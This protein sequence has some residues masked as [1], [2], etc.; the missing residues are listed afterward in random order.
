MRSLHPAPAALLSA[1]TEPPVKLDDLREAPMFDGFA[2]FVILVVGLLVA[3]ALS[4]AVGRTIA[5]VRSQ[6]AALIVER[7]LVTLLG[8]AAIMAALHQLGVGLSVLLGTAGIA[9]I[10]LGFAAQTSASNMISGMFLLAEQPFRVGDAIRVDGVLGEVVNI[11][12]LSVKVRTFDNLLLRIPNETLLK[13]TIT[14][15][16]HYPIRRL[17]VRLGIP[18]GHDVA[19]LREAL[20]ALAAD[21]PLCLAE[22]TPM[23]IVDAFEESAVAIQFSVWSARENYLEMKNSVLEAVQRRIYGGAFPAPLPVR[24]LETRER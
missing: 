15:I 12:M 23:V 5:R 24:V 16:S 9:T 11:D 4:R 3:R 17:D 7:I 13:S 19:P 18:Y 22:P 6:Q 10:A 1:R 14:N 20:F 21:N 2:A 8:T